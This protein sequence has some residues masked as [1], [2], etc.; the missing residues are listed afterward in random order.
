MLR[1]PARAIAW[2]LVLTMGLVAAAQAEPG[3]PNKPI[4]IIVPWPPGAATDAAARVIGEKLS[5]TVGQP[6]VVD[7]RPGANGTIGTSVAAKAPADGYT[8]LVATA[9]T[10]SINP[11]IYRTLPYDAVR[12]FEPITLFATASFVWISRPDLPGSTLSEVIAQAKTKPGKVTFGTW[13]VGS[14]AHV[15]GALLESGSGAELMH[16]PFPGA[17]PAMT[18]LIGGHVDLMPHVA[19]I[20]DQQRRAGKVKILGVAGPK[21]ALPMLP[22]V[23]TL[24]EMGI[25]DAEAGSW[26]GL[27]APAGLPADV[28]KK[29]SDAL[30]DVLTKPEMAQRLTDLGLTPLTLREG[31]FQ[32]FLQRENQRFGD[33]ITRKS[34]RAEQ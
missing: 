8:L 23:P 19:I 11:F 24:A 33:I 14:A 30:N 10:H 31:D 22:D 21:R 20:A 5:Q 34:I 18:A 16:V 27:M 4:K 9:D 6:V 13:G 32:A 29:L 25:K 1:I 26:Y 3:Y 28:R 12:N 17:G 15:A 7:N 2:G